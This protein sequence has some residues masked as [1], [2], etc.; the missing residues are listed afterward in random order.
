MAEAEAVVVKVLP[1]PTAKVGA[2]Y[3]VEPPRLTIEDVIAIRGDPT[4]ML[5]TIPFGP[6]RGKK[7]V[8]ILTNMDWKFS[9]EEKRALTKEERL[10]K[11]KE[12][13]KKHGALWEAN[14]LA[15]EISKRYAGVEGVVWINGVPYP[16]KAIAQKNWRKDHPDLVD[17]YKKEVAPKMKTVTKLAKLLGVT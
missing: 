1:K 13:A 17:K 5:Y 6:A 15:A 10:E 12:R 2:S 3:A 11:F 4:K 9:D 16:R 8:K 14:R 7:V